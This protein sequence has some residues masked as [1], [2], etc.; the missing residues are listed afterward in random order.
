[1][2]QK[3]SLRLEKILRYIIIIMWECQVGLSMWAMI[4]VQQTG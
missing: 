3:Q 4:R 2:K 1:M